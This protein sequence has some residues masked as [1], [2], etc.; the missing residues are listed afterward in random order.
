[1][2]LRRW[3]GAQTHPLAWIGGLNRADF[4]GKVLCAWGA[5]WSLQPP[6]AGEGQPRWGVAGT[7]DS[8]L[9]PTS[10]SHLAFSLVLLSSLHAGK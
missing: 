7:G 5:G 9:H 10:S 6:R 3:G 1:M 4:K 8:G 2:P